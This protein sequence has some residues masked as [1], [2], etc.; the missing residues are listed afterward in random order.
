MKKIIFSLMLLISSTVLYAQEREKERDRD[1]NKEKEYRDDRN[2]N[3]RGNVPSNVWN[4]FHRDYPNADNPRWDRNG[5]GWVATYQDRNYNNREV[6]SYYDRKGR[7]MDSHT[8]WDRRD[9]PGDFDQRFTNRYHPQGDYRV[10]RIDRANGPIVYQVIMD[11]G[12]RTRTIYTDQYG[13]EIKYKD[14]H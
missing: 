4:S 7:R 14:R 2:Y 8:A 9:M 1:R 13:N 10:Y 12:G 6:Q 3:A 11:D 5:R